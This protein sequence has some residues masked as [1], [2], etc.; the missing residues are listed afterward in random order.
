M[1]AGLQSGSMETGGE[2][3]I[4]HGGAGGEEADGEGG[5][6][7]EIVMEDGMR[8]GWGEHERSHF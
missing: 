3:E 1:D 7:E 5:I 8:K 6:E 4:S 2:L